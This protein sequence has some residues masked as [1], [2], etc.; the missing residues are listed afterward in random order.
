MLPAIVKSVPSPSIF[1]PSL[2]KVNPTPDGILMSVV[3]VRFISYP[4]AIVISVPSPEKY[5]P[6]ASNK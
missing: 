5:S 1:S 4:D 6:P 3:A 2:P